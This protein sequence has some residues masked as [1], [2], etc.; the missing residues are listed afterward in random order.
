[1]SLTAMEQRVLA[2]CMEWVHLAWA[3]LMVVEQ[4]VWASWVEWVQ[5]ALAS[6]MDSLVLELF[7]Q[8]SKPSSQTNFHW[9]ALMDDLIASSPPRALLASS[10]R[11]SASVGGVLLQGPGVWLWERGWQGFPPGRP[12]PSQHHLGCSPGMMCPLAQ[13]DLPV[14]GMEVWVWPQDLV[15]LGSSSLICVQTCLIWPRTGTPS[16]PWS[17]L[18]LFLPLVEWPWWGRSSWWMGGCQGAT[19]SILAPLQWIAGC[20]P[21]GKWVCLQVGLHHWPGTWAERLSE[22]SL[23]HSALPGRCL[24]NQSWEAGGPLVGWLFCR[25]H[26][27]CLLLAGFSGAL[28]REWHMAGVPIKPHQ[29]IR[30][31]RS[32]GDQ[33]GQLLNCSFTVGTLAW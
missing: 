30:P 13:K 23:A 24:A 4:R 33:G 10:Q 29:G 17:C 26:C 20:P 9:W 12:L 3:S 2:S 32:T 6:L 31:I 18:P 7:W 8:R 5:M 15:F 22:G 14:C 21:L 1:M 25:W 19:L 28:P 11:W 16:P 27:W